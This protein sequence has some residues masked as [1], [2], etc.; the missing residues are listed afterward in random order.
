[1]ETSTGTRCPLLGHEVQDH[2]RQTECSRGRHPFGR[3]EEAS[4]QRLFLFFCQC[5][6]RGEWELAQACIP[7][8]HH[9][10]GQGPKQVEDILRAIVA[11]PYMLRCGKSTPQRLAWFWLISLEKWL[12]LDH[13]PLPAFLRNETEFLLLLEELQNDL[14]KDVMKELYEAF[15]HSRCESVEAKKDAIALRLSI[16]TTNDLQKILARKPRLVQDLIEFLLSDDTSSSAVEYNNTLQHIYVDFLLASLKS[17][18]KV[19]DSQESSSETAHQIYRTLS[20]MHFN[21]EHQA[22]ELR[23]VFKELFDICIDPRCLL[24]EEHLLGCLLRKQTHALISLYENV[25][26]ERIREMLVGPKTPEK[27][28]TQLILSLADKIPST[29]IKFNSY[30]P[31]IAYWVKN[32]CLKLNTYKSEIVIFRKDASSWHSNLVKAYQTAQLSGAKIFL[33][34]IP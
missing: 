4:L 14:V 20:L 25:A 31:E 12:A 34:G 17:L 18:Q 27:E 6:Q 5:L 32:N 9:W 11:C 16:R 1:M 2:G 19:E 3:E 26:T 29:R 24:K 21:V 22:G 8:L 15:L 10:K 28:E 30:M 13:K 33:V 23:Y 7:Q